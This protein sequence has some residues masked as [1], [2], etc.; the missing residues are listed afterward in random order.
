MVYCKKMIIAF[1]TKKQVIVFENRFDSFA[2]C[3]DRQKHKENKNN[4]ELGFINHFVIFFH[5]I[6]QIEPNKPIKYRFKIPKNGN[7]QISNMI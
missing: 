4:F 6:Y 5:D 1:L 7:N 3:I 2:L